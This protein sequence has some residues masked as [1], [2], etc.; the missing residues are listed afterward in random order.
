[1]LKRG[2]LWTLWQHGPSL[3][4]AFILWPPHPQH[5]G[6]LTSTGSTDLANIAAEALSSASFG[7]HQEALKSPLLLF[8]NPYYLCISSVQRW[9]LWR[10]WRLYLLLPTFTALVLVRHVGNLY[11][12]PLWFASSE[13][14]FVVY[15]LLYSSVFSLML[16]LIA[17]PRH[18]KI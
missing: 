10:R 4:H 6:F 3:S 9:H 15:V 5:G 17:T 7:I 12:Q 18:S 1:M 14:A 2:K 8:G 16:T 13:N 11:N